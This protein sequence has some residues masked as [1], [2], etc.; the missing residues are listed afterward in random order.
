MGFFCIISDNFQ[1]SIENSIK[2][3]T[4]LCTTLLFHIL[5]QSNTIWW[6]YTQNTTQKQPKIHFSGTKKTF[7][8]S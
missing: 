6:N 5:E 2:Y 7:A 8:N 1:D 3:D 4:L